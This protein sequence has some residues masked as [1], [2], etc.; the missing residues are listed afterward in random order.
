MPAPFPTSRAVADRPGL[1][2]RDGRPDRAAHR[3]PAVLGLLAALAAAGCQSGLGSFG[4]KPGRDSVSEKL[5]DTKGIRGPLERF[6]NRQTQGA[7]VAPPEAHAEYA[8]V[9]K[10]FREEAYAD[11]EKASKSLEKRYPGT[12]VAEDAQFLLAESLFRQRKY[13]WAQDGYDRLVKDFPATRHLD[14]SSE[15]LYAIAREW[16]RFPEVATQG[17]V[18]PVNLEKT[19]ETPS[20]TTQPRPTTYDPTRAVPFVPNLFDR[21]RPVFDTDGRALQ[22]LKSIWLNDPRG[23]L[24]DDA[25]MLTASHYLLKEDYLEADRY[26]TMLREEYPKSPYLKDS[27]VL[28]SFVK[29][30]SYQGAD[31]DGR[32]L[33]EAQALDESTLRLFPEAELKSRVGEQLERMQVADA[34]RDWEMVEFWDRKGKP[35]AVAMYCREILRKHPSTPAADKARQTL[36]RIERQ[37]APA[38]NTAPAR[39]AERPARLPTDG[40]ESPAPRPTPLRRFLDGMPRL[41][42]VPGSGAKSATPDPNGAPPREFDPDSLGPP[43]SNGAPPSSPGRNVPTEPPRIE[44]TEA[45]GRAR[46]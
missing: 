14:R 45:P 23:P 20:P 16:L 32:P 19:A 15:R 5:A 28:G 31:Y 43:D 9:E 36:A 11:V 46:V 27:F 21:S 37:P 39:P 34:E 12:V 41:S 26:F 2:S 44:Q 17:D 40:T 8:R 42:P 13:S 3:L 7:A 1:R 25:L 6:L 22:A 33:Q 38:P 30:M 24:A 29:Q 10:L 18:Q 35:Q 4:A